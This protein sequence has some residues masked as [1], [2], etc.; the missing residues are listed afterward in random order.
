MTERKNIEWV[1]RK[2]G[3]YL[4]SVSSRIAG[5]L[6]LAEAGYHVFVGVPDIRLREVDYIIRNMPGTQ[7]RMLPSDALE[8]YGK[9]ENL[10]HITIFEEARLDFFKEKGMNLFETIIKENE[11]FILIASFTACNK[12]VSNWLPEL[13]SYIFAITKEPKTM[14]HDAYIKVLQHSAACVN[15]L[16]EEKGILGP[17][18]DESAYSVATGRKDVCVNETSGLNL[19]GLDLLDYV[20][21]VMT[22][23]MARC[24][25]GPD[26]K[27]STGIINNYP[28]LAQGVWLHYESK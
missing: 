24:I 28:T 26:V 21:H 12:I 14:S 20:N 27:I 16:I 23:C 8:E 17:S 22:H 5:A 1:L 18:L 2:P 15:R 11:P 6:T 13:P 25:K 19:Y 7:G 10:P 3:E 9:L 4:G